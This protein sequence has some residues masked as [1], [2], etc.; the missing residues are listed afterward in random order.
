MNYAVQYSCR[1]YLTVMDTMSL[2]SVINMTKDHTYRSFVRIAESWLSLE[3]VLD[4][5]AMDFQ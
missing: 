3:K 2:G 1:A 5:T 4:G